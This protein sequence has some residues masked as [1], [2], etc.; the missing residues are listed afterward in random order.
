MR[1]LFVISHVALN[2]GACCSSFVFLRYSG[3][4][5]ILSTAFSGCTKLFPLQSL[6]VGVFVFVCFRPQSKRMA[7][8]GELYTY[9]YLLSLVLTNRMAR[10]KVHAE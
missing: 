1:R 10:T 7:S 5:N 2:E 6:S 3:T 8:S 9:L 4:R